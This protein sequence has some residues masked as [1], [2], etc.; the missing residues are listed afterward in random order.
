MIYSIQFNLAIASAA[1]LLLFCISAAT[2]QTLIVINE[3][4]ASNNETVAD[5]DGDFED[6]I[7][8][9]NEGDAPARLTGYGLT[10]REGDFF[11]WVFPDTSLGPGEFMLIWASGKNRRSPGAPLHTNFSIAEHGEPL[12]LSDVNGEKLD[13]VP[14]IH[15]PTDY[16][17]GRSQDGSDNWVFFSNP[18]P[19]FPNA[20]ESHE[21]L[22][23]PPQFSHNAGFY[24][25][26]F[27][28]SLTLAN[29][30]ANAEIYFT[31][32]GSIPGPD[33]GTR[34]MEGDTIRIEN[35]T[36]EP[37]DISM[38]RT[39]NIDETDP[40]NDGWKPPIGNVFKGTVVRAVAWAPNSKPL[41]VA[42]Q[43]YFVGDDLRD[44]YQLPIVSL[45]TDRD[46]FFSDATGIYVPDNFWLRGEEW[47]RPVHFEF[48]EKG[49]EPVL[50]QD[51]GVRIHGGTS[52]A[53]P[54]KSLRMY[55][56]RSYGET[57]FEHPLIPGAPADRYKRFLLRNSGNDWDKAYFRDALMQKLVEHTGVETQYYQPVVVFLNGE[58]WGI[59][60]IRKRYDH[61]YFETMY[62]LDRDDLVL[63]EGDAEIKEG[64]PD[65]RKSYLQL[66][67]MMDQ[68]PDINHPQVWQMVRN[69][70]DLGNFRDYQIANIYFRNTDWPGNNIDF[71]RKRTDGPQ[72]D[73]PPG[74]DGRWRWL[75]FDTD[76]GFNLDYTYVQGHNA[77][78]QHNTLSFAV[79]GAPASWP[80][81][82]WSVQ[83]LRGALRNISFR[84]DFINRFADLL[85]TAFDPGRVEQEM[86]MMYEM[87]KPHMAEH[88][89]RW[90]GPETMQ[91]WE[92]EVASMRDFARRR[93]AAQRR[94]IVSHFGLRGLVNFT[95]DVNDP[96]GGHITI[97]SVDIRPGE[98]GV[99]DEP[100]PW[101]GIYFQ[102][103]PVSVTA[104]P[105]EGYEFTG[106][107]GHSQTSE[108]ITIRT[109]QENMELKALFG[110]VDVSAEPVEP[111]PHLPELFRLHPARPNPFNNST[112]LTVS[113]PESG[114]LRVYAYTVEG[115]RV[116]TLKNRELQ[117][118]QH[119]V[120]IDAAG[121][122]SGIYI[123]TAETGSHRQSIPVT[124]VK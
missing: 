40:L 114:Q 76:F 94:H 93:P 30:P 62:G 4:Q 45:A 16:S 64:L 83:M 19:G 101:S 29:H 59:H 57:W 120:V 112:L 42:T 86:D 118:G 60:N 108:T 56:R 32:D 49:G 33:N 12:R 73:A 65:D 81:P 111:D 52:R 110:Q 75:L 85:N 13:S 63:F 95:L 113:M 124:L 105:A 20:G 90:R 109:L 47:E 14:P 79:H 26:S 68:E 72:D 116:A 6:W 88:V 91:E 66:R 3:F 50:A 34:L 89:A 21:Q 122:A 53:R 18:T 24:T 77:R 80:N 54:I 2:A 10:D 74:H 1:I 48:F 44:R 99:T 70:I 31:I 39:N 8:I 28:L 38:I 106:W 84:N 7:E 37:N 23:E 87:L 92:D 100:W 103:I 61:R 35:R 69:R 67:E 119:D 117:R 11:R 25:Q 15:V 98:V 78:E 123:I 82:D 27:A 107:E 71:W 97:N 121:W 104:K 22:L 41:R 51:A 5:E 55:A 96:A 115:R 46:H 58:Y 36:S 9:F 17:Y 102:D 43:T